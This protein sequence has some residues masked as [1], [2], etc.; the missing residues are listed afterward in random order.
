MP[1]SENPFEGP[2]IY[3]DNPEPEQEAGEK[4]GGGIADKLRGAIDSLQ[5]KIPVPL[6]IV[7]GALVLLIIVIAG[8]FLLASGGATTTVQILVQN[9]A[10]VPVKAATV[11][12]SGLEKPLEL[13][14]DKEGLVS[15]EAKIGGTINARISKQGYGT[16]TQTL[17]VEKD[18]KLISVVLKAPQLVTGG[19]TITF[20]GPDKKKLI[21]KEVRAKLSCSREGTFPQEEYVTE[22]GELKVTP[23][24]NCGSINITASAGGLKTAT[25]LAL[26]GR[27]QVITFEGIENPKGSLQINVKDA[28]TGFFLDGISVIMASDSGAPTG[29]IGS[30]SFGL[31]SF[32]IEAGSYT[33]LVSD[34]A[35]QYASQTVQAEV[36]ANGSIRKDV[37]LSKDVKLRAKV[38][39]KDKASGA[40]IQGA[41]VTIFDSAKKVV[42]EISVNANGEAIFAL[43][44]NGSYSFIASAENYLPSSET[45][46]STFDYERGAEASFE[47][48]LQKCTPDTCGIL[49]ARVLD[50]DGL[51]VE[52][53]RVMLLDEKGFIQ[54]AYSYKVT[55]F[56]GLIAAFTNIAEGKYSLLAQ[57][58]PASGISEQFSVSAKETNYAEVKMVIGKGTVQVSATNLNGEALE[59]GRAEIITDYGR[60]LGT[61]ALDAQGKGFL[62]DVKADKKVFVVVRK[63]GYAPYTTAPKQVL[64]DKSVQ[65][66]VSLEESILGDRPAIE[67]L[68]IFSE[69]G[70]EV[71]SFSG[72]KKYS[73]RFLLS[74]PEGREF[75]EA[76]LFLRAGEKES[77]EKDSISIGSVS[78]PFASVERGL[79]YNP[80][81]GTNG[82]EELT[83]GKAKWASVVMREPETGSYEFEA[84]LSVNSGITKGTFM[85][86][87]Y[88]SWGIE[89][90]DY[91]RD[92]LDLELGSAAETSAKKGLYAQAYEKDY[93]EGLSENCSNE[94]CFGERLLDE[95][96]GIYVAAPYNLRTF[97]PYRLEFSI[98]NNSQ[99]IHDNAS[100]KIRNTS[101]GAKTG[102]EISVNSYS[103]TNADSQKFSSSQPKFET[104]AISLG[105][106]RQN[107]TVAGELSI[108]AKSQNY[109]S[110]EFTIV[111]DRQEVL[112]SFVY[113]TPFSEEDIDLSVEPEE[114]IAFV[115]T[116]INVTALYA[117]GDDKGFGIQDALV[118]VTKTAP[119]RSRTTFTGTTNFQGKATVS[120]PASSP[121][122]R[123]RITLEKPGLGAKTI[124]KVVSLDVVKFDPE[125]INI[126][127]N[128]GSGNEASATLTME[129]VSQKEILVKKFRVSGAFKGML[130]EDRMNNFLAQY[131]GKKISPGELFGTEI[132][133]A[134]GSES[135]YL[136]APIKVKG[137]VIIEFG[138]QNDDS[139][140]W[141][142]EL[143]FQTTINLAELPENAPCIIIS[144][145]D[146]SDST[147]ASQASTEFE[148]QNNC[149]D[150]QSEPMELENLQAQVHWTG[151]DGI[152]GQVELAV[153]DTETG[154]ISSEILQEGI[155]SR[156]V[157]KL[158][159][160][161]IYPARLTFV[162]KPGTIGKRAQFNVKIDAGIQTN[163]G[164]QLVGAGNDVKADIFVINL[165]QCMQFTP[166][167]EQGIVIDRRNESAEFS[168]DTSDCGPINLDL[169]FCEGGNDQ[170]RGGTEEGGINL[171]PWS[172]SNVNAESKTITVER[173]SIPGF[174]GITIEARPSGGTWRKVAELDTIVKPPQEDYFEMDKYKFTVIGTGSKD[175]ATLTNSMVL[176]DVE[177]TAGVC[178]YAAAA[179]DSSFGGAGAGL[180]SLA[181]GAIAGTAAGWGAAGIGVLVSGAASTFSAGPLL[182]LMW[183]VPCV[184]IGVIVM[185]IVMIMMTLGGGSQDPC[186]PTTTQSLQA[187][188]INLAGTADQS[189]ERY[190]PPDALD[191]IL[192]DRRISGEWNLDVT[193]GSGSAGK[194]GTQKAGVVFTNRG[195]DR[196]EAIYAI[197]ETRAT[198]HIH[199]DAAHQSASVECKGSDFGMFWI[200]PASCSNT[201]D[202]TYSQKFHLKF[203]VAEEKAPLTKV[204][205]DTYACQSGT[206][207]G[208]TGP[209]ALPRIKMNWS[210]KESQNGISYNQCDATNPGAVYCDATQFTIELNKKLYR[211]HDFLA[212]NNFDL[213]CPAATDIA[214]QAESEF[215][216]MSTN[217]DVGSGLIG[218]S[219]VE[220]IKGTNSVTIKATVKNNTALI[221]NAVVDVNMGNLQDA[222]S[223]DFENCKI[224][225]NGIEG[226]GGTKQ[227]E[228]VL[229][230]NEDGAH[231]IIAKVA[232]ASNP[233]IVSRAPATAGFY[234][235][236][237]STGHPLDSQDSAAE[238]GGGGAPS[239]CEFKSTETYYEV[240]QI[241]R[242]I[243][244]NPNIKWTASVPDRA[245]LQKLLMFDAYLMKDNY[246]KEF[247][248]DFADYY[249]K[250]AFEDTDSYF[251]RLNTD[252][253][254]TPYGFAR[255]MDKGLFVLTRKYVQ[256]PELP[257]AGLY[258]VEF[259][260]YFG[261]D[262]WRFFDSTGKPKAGVSVVVYKASDAF[263]NSPFY[264]MPIDGL[265]GLR[266]NNF[267]RQGY[268]T[269]FRNNSSRIIAISNEL[270]QAKTYEDAGSN[271]VA[272]ASVETKKDFYSLNTSP[273]TRGMVLEVSKGK[274]GK[275]ATILFQ[276]SQ[277]TPVL[278]KATQN[279]LSEEKFGA[280][281]SML[282]NNNAVGAG[283]TLSYWDGA[284]SCFDFTGV[285][286]TEAFYQK[287]DR[288]ATTEDMLLDWK[289]IYGIDW[290]RATK[291]GDVYLR[292]IF[293]TNPNDD[294]VIKAVKGPSALDFFTP[295]SKGGL[296][297]L[298]GVS[299]MPYNNFAGGSVGTI[300]SIDDVFALVEAGQVCV[301]NS[302][303]STKFWWNP[304]AIYTQ[305]GLQ[306]N[307]SDETNRLVAGSTCIG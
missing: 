277:A 271:A 105:D 302:G 275:A 183:C 301:T 132:L 217:T 188:V 65:F 140:A 227:G 282:E 97:S 117:S 254:G 59:F 156:L 252:S 92:P 126:S 15:F 163:S 214:S 87:F 269:A 113:F 71:K 39:V 150:S 49:K 218:V 238:N 278:M 29:I 21:G 292:T 226:N 255:L 290:Q 207:I 86:L 245:E 72:G 139:V 276:P 257:G 42:Q 124:E 35:A 251:N 243:D 293:Y 46:F 144:A 239:S 300:D 182:G 57:K 195:A 210:W 177:V 168:I 127:V 240:P 161:R 180:Q 90:A 73:A 265:V 179:Q 37:R 231:G 130:D 203:K 18:S 125:E 41:K 296:V 228:C 83:N 222:F 102:K 131:E 120:V 60:S 38:S 48:K 93:F 4:K 229:P 110:L 27:A 209:G 61:I 158:E 119:D 85:P 272:G 68:G 294:V 206:A 8:I 204:A 84:E 14:T 36:L 205:F 267:T 186:A 151:K 295:D 288:A 249:T 40:K 7:A 31:A 208:R 162:P 232:Q 24:E 305:T 303:D 167:A 101:D 103:F 224:N 55:D 291:K 246:S 154:S 235:G 62:A 88:R 23:P 266:G 76:G 51:P 284:G 279:S 12:I 5:E 122:T 100:L 80:P 270:P 215:N 118:T 13:Q 135:Q 152:I 175:S 264:S 173:G 11:S 114:I 286:V 67:F 165:D 200:N 261:K 155:W 187:Y 146:W 260:I 298:N 198:E 307:I 145:K 289:N 74:V 1:D 250:Q 274:T 89:N 213:G 223:Q 128:R 111:S 281:Y 234:S 16:E 174:Y 166:E 99:Q 6:P 196:N 189:Y 98:T 43:S 211:L 191:V 258:H 33:A 137:K 171:R 134:L 299:G 26:L 142:A 230:V 184:V 262:D 160:R 263:P 143:P 148:I 47:V 30:T 10:K 70:T 58:F 104:D 94:F 164:S 32:S 193:D 78:A 25:G 202:K 244:S 253:N 247:F 79:T 304:Q 280:F 194:N 153:T 138:L 201:Y 273:S 259:G 236:I 17:A 115:P 121:G 82:E 106:F 96:S 95:T 77:L 64:P 2:A 19:V 3:R 216:S 22:T 136:D 157:E 34:P 233:G 170:C 28:S 221:E 178:D 66:N 9:E 53:A 190:L 248:A 45:G 75:D 256:S 133:S 199:G 219:K 159:P 123:F 297:A 268:G 50:E 172:Y 91:L 242:F 287:P 285:P 241:M 237:F 112:D 54:T 147:I 129:S 69:Q 63:E 225:V 116:D 169:R 149:V 52:N 185:I 107:K 212:T 141:V 56:N 109:S 108:E 306:R 20:A 181:M 220:A 44:E 176:E 197:A 283:N 192:S 81:L